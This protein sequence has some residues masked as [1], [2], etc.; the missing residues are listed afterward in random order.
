MTLTG[1]LRRH[2]IGPIGLLIRRHGFLVVV[3]D[4]VKRFA[5]MPPRETLDGLAIAKDREDEI[6]AT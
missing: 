1:G 5:G 2:R 3:A 6:F 4:R